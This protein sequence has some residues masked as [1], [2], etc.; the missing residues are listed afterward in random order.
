METYK[1]FD[2]KC[3][4]FTVHIWCFSSVCWYFREGRRGTLSFF[5]VLMSGHF[6]HWR[7]SNNQNEWYLFLT[8]KRERKKDIFFT[9]NHHGCSY[10]KHK[11]SNTDE[12]NGSHFDLSR[13]FFGVCGQNETIKRRHHQI[14]F[15][16]NISFFKFFP[17]SHLKILPLV[18]LL[19]NA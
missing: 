19:L 9:F 5:P 12:A 14:C 16:H 1:S 7:R 11:K 4:N 3:G 15:P 2:V 8:I 10:C 17:K 13:Q 18:R 6:G